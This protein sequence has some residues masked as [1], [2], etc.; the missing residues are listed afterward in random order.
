MPEEEKSSKIDLTKDYNL[1]KEVIEK[2]S[3]LIARGFVDLD[4]II[5]EAKKGSKQVARE[6][7]KKKV[8]IHKN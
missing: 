5:E 8:T 7:K 4:W 2:L 3:H 1:S 6:I